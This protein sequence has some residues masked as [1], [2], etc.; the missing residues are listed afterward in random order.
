M[1]IGIISV[2]SVEV[3]I[4][5]ISVLS[6]EGNSQNDLGSRMRRG[7]RQ[8]TRIIFY[9]KIVYFQWA[10][11]EIVRAFV[12]SSCTMVAVDFL[13]AKWRCGGLFMATRF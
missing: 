12:R 11:G 7:S 3:I 1:I 8:H 4:E 6:V 2:L 13:R 10:R 5:I 9:R